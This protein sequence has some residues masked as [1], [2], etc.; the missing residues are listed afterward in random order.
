MITAL[1]EAWKKF[2]KYAMG[3]GYTERRLNAYVMYNQQGELIK[4]ISIRERDHKMVV[5][6][7]RVNYYELDMNYDALT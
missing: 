7:D 4:L 1:N 6:E 2:E 5:W 3:K